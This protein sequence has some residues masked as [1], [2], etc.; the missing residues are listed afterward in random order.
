M[1]VGAWRRRRRR[2][3]FRKPIALLWKNER[4]DAE[5]LVVVLGEQVPDHS[6]YESNSVLAFP[7]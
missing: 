7:K 1:R 5:V 6:V 4:M 2:L 3:L